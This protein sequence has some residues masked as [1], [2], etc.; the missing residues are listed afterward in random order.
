MWMADEGM[1]LLRYFSLHF[2][3]DLGV[4]RPL[5]SARRKARWARG[6]RAFCTASS[7][8]LVEAAVVTSL[9][10]VGLCDAELAA[11]ELALSEKV[12]VGHLKQAYRYAK[13]AIAEGDKERAKIRWRRSGPA[14]T[15]R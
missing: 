4:Y 15:D 2:E 1:W 13:L 6:C 5:S 11:A 10:Y 7:S 9:Q 12:R 14:L 8:L 3:T